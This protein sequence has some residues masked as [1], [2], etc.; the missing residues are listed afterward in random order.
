MAKAVIRGKGQVTIPAS[1]RRAVHLEEG[2][3]I[4]VELVAD[5]ILLRPCKVIDPTQAWFW[6]PE[7]Q[8]KERE[9]DEDIAAGRVERFESDEE[10]LAA[11]D[12]RMKP[13]DADP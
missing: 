13:L 12:A 11:L 10:F 2:D 6:T 1:I 3:P 8:A 4:E 9:A 7:W 5:G